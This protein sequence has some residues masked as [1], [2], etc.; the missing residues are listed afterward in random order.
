[1]IGPV[2]K[3]IKVVQGKE[4]YAKLAELAIGPPGSLDKFVVTNQDD[5]KLIQR[6]RKEVG[7]GARD[8]NVSRISEKAVRSKYATPAPPPGVETVTSVLSSDNAM[9]WNFLIDSGNIDQSALCDSKGDSESALLI[10]DNRGASIRGG[11]VKKVYFLPEGDHWE[12]K[13]GMKTMISNERKMIQT[14]GTDR[15]EAIRV[16][17]EELRTIA[18]DL[19]RAKQEQKGLDDALHDAKVKWNH[20]TKEYKKAT[21]GIKKAE[22][23]L[24]KLKAEA[25]ESEEPQEHDTTEYENDVQEKETEVASCKNK[26][27]ALLQEIESLRPAVDEKRAEIDEGMSFFSFLFKRHLFTHEAPHYRPNVLG[28]RGSQPESHGRHGSRRA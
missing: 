4:K 26:E 16:A 5:L 11:N 24:E 3:Y 14:I 18:D 6:L 2:G 28:S 8:C 10:S 15:R 20:S 19:K 12:T 17:K 27:A 23:N 1:V 21:T 13:G 7:C 22:E 25:D 9:A